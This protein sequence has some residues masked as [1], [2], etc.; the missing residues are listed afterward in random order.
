MSEPRNPSPDT[1]PEI[2]GM[3]NRLMK[4]NTQKTHKNCVIGFAVF[5][6]LAL[7]VLPGIA[8]SAPSALVSLK[9]GFASKLSA[10]EAYFKTHQ[11]QRSRKMYL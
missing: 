5:N 1:L 4:V 8:G 3:K 7:L 2:A 9:I 10:R 11:C 6:L